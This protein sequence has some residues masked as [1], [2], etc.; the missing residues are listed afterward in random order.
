MGMFDRFF[1]ESLTNAPR[2]AAG[3]SMACAEFQTK[4]LDCMLA[5]YSIDVDGASPSA[6]GLRVIV[7]RVIGVGHPN[8][9][10]LSKSVHPASSVARSSGAAG[11]DSS[12]VSFPGV[13]ASLTIR[14]GRVTDVVVT[15]ETEED[16]RKPFPANTVWGDSEF[17]RDGFV[18]PLPDG[19]PRAKWGTDLLERE[20]VE[21][22]AR[23]ARAAWWTDTMSQTHEFLPSEL[24]AMVAEKETAVLFGLIDAVR[25][26]PADKGSWL[27]LGDYL[28]THGRSIGEAIASGGEP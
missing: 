3:H 11:K 2:C 1:F 26:T 25:Q 24:G 17:V 28:Q 22:T 8:S 21:L 23:Q 10:A 13:T 12:N 18:H 27:V 9:L 20:R 16:I 7:A 19:H 14:H 15:A 4:D 6:E 5:L